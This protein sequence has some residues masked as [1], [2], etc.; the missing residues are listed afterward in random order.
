MG[1]LT[2]SIRSS[3]TSENAVKAKFAQRVALGTREMPES[4]GLVS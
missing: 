1:A 2:L 3:P 4:P